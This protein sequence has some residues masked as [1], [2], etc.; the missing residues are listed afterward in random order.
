MCIFIQNPYIFTFT[1]TSN[2]YIDDIYSH[3]KHTYDITNMPTYMCFTQ[4]LY[5]IMYNTYTSQAIYYVLTPH[6]I[7]CTILTCSIN[8]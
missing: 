5:I 7:L 8:T 3:Y 4:K 6:H 1:Q 2:P